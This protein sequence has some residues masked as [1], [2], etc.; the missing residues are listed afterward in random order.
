QYFRPA[1]PLTLDTYSGG[2]RDGKQALAHL[3]ISSSY[4]ATLHRNGHITDVR[5][6]GGMRSNSFDAAFLGSL[7][8]LDASEAVPP[9]PDSRFTADVPIVLQVKTFSDSDRLIIGPFAK[10]GVTLA[11][12]RT[13]T[14]PVFAAAA[15]KPGT[16]HLRYPSD[17][18]TRDIEGEVVMSFVVNADGT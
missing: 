7:R 2:R 5:T 18:R 8:A 11:T 6:G 4:R 1:S 16:G 17:M 15:Q 10:L 13:P 9:L 3:V 12:L 14:L